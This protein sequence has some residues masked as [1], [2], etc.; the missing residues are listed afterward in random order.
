MGL[1]VFINAGPW[2]P[3]PPWGYG[4]VENLLVYLIRKLRGRGHR[5]ILGTVGQS[6]IEVERQ[7]SR[8]RQG[9]H[10][11]ITAPIPSAIVACS[12]SG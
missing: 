1:T 2:L 7:V 8:F 12:P 9:Q 4:G 6:R 5:V 11:R 10:P 3:I